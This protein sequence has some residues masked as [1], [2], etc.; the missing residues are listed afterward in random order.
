MPKTIQIHAV[1]ARNSKRVKH[2]EG[3]RKSI[4]HQPSLPAEKL[5]KSLSEA[6]IAVDPIHFLS[7]LV[8]LCE[9]ERL[10]SKVI[11]A[12]KIGSR[13]VDDWNCNASSPQ[14]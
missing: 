12:R 13:R 4:N 9:S 3:G 10:S 1:R 7:S 2:L 6:R 8:L 11:R 5:G 14:D